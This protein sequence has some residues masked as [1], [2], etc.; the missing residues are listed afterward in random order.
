LPAPSEAFDANGLAVD[1]LHPNVALPGLAED[2]LV[3]IEKGGKL[4]STTMEGSS[5]R[6]KAFVGGCIVEVPDE[7]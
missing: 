4:L 2:V 3:V 7:S 1:K 6:K 5:N